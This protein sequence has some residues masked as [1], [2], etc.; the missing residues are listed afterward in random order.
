MSWHRM[1][2]CSLACLVLA[3]AAEGGTRTVLQTAPSSDPRHPSGLIQG[4]EWEFVGRPGDVV[5]IGVDT[6]DDK[7]EGS[8]LLDPTMLLRRPDGSI[9]AIGDDE[10][11]CSRPPVCGYACPALR[12]FPLDQNGRW[13]I[14]VRDF[15][16]ASETG[17]FCTGGGYNLSL[18][19][20]AHALE[21]LRLRTDDGTVEQLPVNSRGVRPRKPSED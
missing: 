18:T 4:D 6:R 21:S 3:A 7:Y 1:A 13:I 17:A 5:T 9:A 11:E 8:A 12:S 10:A 14:I 15:G 20:P 16:G 2:A 19:G